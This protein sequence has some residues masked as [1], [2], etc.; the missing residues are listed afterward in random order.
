MS[1]WAGTALSCSASL[2]WRAAS[3][4][5]FGQ[6]SSSRSTASCSLPGKYQQSP[7]VGCLLG[8]GRSGTRR[9]GVGAGTVSRDELDARLL[10]QSGDYRWRI[11]P[12]RQFDRTVFFQVTTIVP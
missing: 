12:G 8:V 6:C 5:W 7:S 4:V 9:V 10:L 1:T 3:F 11:A 2:A